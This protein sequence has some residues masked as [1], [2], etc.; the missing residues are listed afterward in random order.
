MRLHTWLLV[1]HVEQEEED[2][3]DGNKSGPPG[4]KEHDD[5]GDDRPEERRPLAVVSERGS[6]PW[7]EDAGWWARSGAS[8]GASTTLALPPTPRARVPACAHP[9]PTTAGSPEAGLEALGR[10]TR[11]PWLSFGQMNRLHQGGGIQIWPCQHGAMKERGQ[12]ECDPAWLHAT[13]P[14][15]GRCQGQLPRGTTVGHHGPRAEK[16]W[17]GGQPFDDLGIIR[18]SLSRDTLLPPAR[19]FSE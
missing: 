10:T 2:D 1:D 11:P 19:N 7:S 17:P 5:H 4:E 9:A 15:Q 18:K 13:G 14:Y 6:P 8:S 3:A 12:E 16:R